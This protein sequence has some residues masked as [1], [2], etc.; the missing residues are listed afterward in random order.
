MVQMPLT[1]SDSSMDAEPLLVGWK[2][3][4]GLFKLSS[5]IR[6]NWTLPK[7]LNLAQISGIMLIPLWEA[8]WADGPNSYVARSAVCEQQLDLLS[9]ALKLPEDNATNLGQI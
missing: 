3:N 8:P 7:N 6:P 9:P 4:L 5:S 2:F 1:V